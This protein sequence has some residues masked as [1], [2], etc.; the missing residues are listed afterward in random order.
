MSAVNFDM[1]C[2]VVEC[3][4]LEEPYWVSGIKLLFVQKCS[5]AL[6]MMIS[7]ILLIL[8]NRLIGR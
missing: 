2:T 3:L 1:A 5:I 4:L 6:L 8:G 7:K